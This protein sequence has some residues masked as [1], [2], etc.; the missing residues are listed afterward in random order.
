MPSSLRSKW[1]VIV[2]AV[3]ACVAAL[4]LADIRLGLDLKGGSRMVMQIQVQDAFKAEA[5]KP[6][7][8]AE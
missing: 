6:K 2:L 8:D 3:A 1:I 4:G 5:E 7:G